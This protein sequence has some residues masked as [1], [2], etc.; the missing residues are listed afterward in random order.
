MLA[1]MGQV[2]CCISLCITSLGLA[3]LELL[4][5]FSW[6]AEAELLCMQVKNKCL[7]IIAK[8][9]YYSLPDMLKE[10]LSGLTISSFIAGLLVSRDPPTLA[11]ALILAELLI[12]KVP[13]DYKR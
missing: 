12:A 8:V 6:G 13:E 10:Q 1:S 5:A 4:R 2:L 11:S 9:L 3:K 7:K